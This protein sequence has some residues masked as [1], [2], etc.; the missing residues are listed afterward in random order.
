MLVKTL[1]RVSAYFEDVYVKVEVEQ[2]ER[3]SIEWGLHSTAWKENCVSSRELFL[4]KSFNFLHIAINIS[5]MYALM[6]SSA[7]LQ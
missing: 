4:S 3:G 2:R 7:W 1:A 5:A 6:L